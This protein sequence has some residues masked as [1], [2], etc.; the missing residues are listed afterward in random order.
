MRSPRKNALRARVIFNS[1]L[2]AASATG[3]LQANEWQAWVGTQSR[4]LGSQAL[5]FLPNEFWIHT[6]DSIRWT[7]ASTEIHTVTFL[8][9]VPGQPGQVRQ[10]FFGAFGVQIG[11]PGIT[12]DGS[13]FDVP[14]V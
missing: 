1:I 7:I 6:S 11:C 4:D 10:P 14:V 2:L 5:A 9:Q 12:R 8:Q 13:S 3:M